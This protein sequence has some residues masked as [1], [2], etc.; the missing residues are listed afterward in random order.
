MRE[1]E[2]GLVDAFRWPSLKASGGFQKWGA[3]KSIPVCYNP[4]YKDCQ[5][6]TLIFGSPRM[7]TAWKP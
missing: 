6:G 1:L 4:Y 3:P 7:V 5:K 2:K